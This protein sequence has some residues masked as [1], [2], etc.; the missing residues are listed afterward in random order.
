MYLDLGAN[1]GNTIQLFLLDPSMPPLSHLNNKDAFNFPYQP[2]EFRVVG[3][4]AMKATHGAALEAIQRRFPEQVEILWAAAGTEDGAMLRIY[5]DE[6]A[7]AEAEWGAGFLPLFSSKF[8]DVPTVDVS[9]WLAGNACKCD[10]VVVKMNI[11]GS[12]FNVLDKMLREGTLCLM[13]V[14][15][16]Y[17]HPK[18][19]PGNESALVQRIEEVYKPAFDDCGVLT[20][21]WSVH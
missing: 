13:D 1:R 21:V 11:E 20:E 19:F 16:L 4:E 12:E 8:V 9:S 10:F 15:H 6:K 14:A 18:F 5:R 7:V 2:S 3:V 17:F